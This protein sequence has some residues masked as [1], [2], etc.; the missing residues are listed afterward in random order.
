MPYQHTQGFLALAGHVGFGRKSWNVKSSSRDTWWQWVTLRVC[1]PDFCKS[2]VL[3]LPKVKHPII[4]SPINERCCCRRYSAQVM[5][6]LWEAFPL[7]PWQQKVLDVLDISLLFVREEVP[8][9]PLTQSVNTASH[10]SQA[11]WSLLVSKGHLSPLFI[12]SKPDSAFPDL[13]STTEWET[14]FSPSRSFTKFTY[15]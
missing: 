10:M 15:G 4:M 2:T 1:S 9:F 5:D 11:A 13:Q 8:R 7:W 14:S 3:K 12:I 6:L